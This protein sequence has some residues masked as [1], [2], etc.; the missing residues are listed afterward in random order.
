MLSTFMH[1]PTVF[2]KYRDQRQWGHS[3]ENGQVRAIAPPTAGR[4]VI[5]SAIITPS[6]LRHDALALAYYV[7]S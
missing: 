2:K 3:V 6:W 1:Y 7:R 5:L 4:G